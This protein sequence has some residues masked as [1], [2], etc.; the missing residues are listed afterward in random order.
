[1]ALITPETRVK[2][3]TFSLP[4]IAKIC[5]GLRYNNI[6][7]KIVQQQVTINLLETVQYIIS[8]GAPLFMR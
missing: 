4:K 5:S 3:S 8:S 2:G 6:L 7:H 1:M